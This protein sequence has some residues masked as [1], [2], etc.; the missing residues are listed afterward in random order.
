MEFLEERWNSQIS[1]RTSMAK[2]IL[3]RCTDAEVRKRGEQMGLDTPVVHALNDENSLSDLSMKIHF[4]ASRF[5]GY[6]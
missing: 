6:S 3:W 4:S 1:G 5:G 2:A